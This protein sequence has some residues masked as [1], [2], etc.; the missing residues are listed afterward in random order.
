MLL[1]GDLIYNNDFDCNC[2]YAIYDCTNGTSWHDEEAI[3]ST[4][5][6]GW[7]KP[8]DQILDMKIGYIT[9]DKDVI[10]IEA[11]R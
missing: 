3:F 8:L 7:H 4:V 1:I 5:R 11:T 2:N 6:D 9:T 10:V